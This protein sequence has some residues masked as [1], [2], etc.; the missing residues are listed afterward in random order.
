MLIPRRYSHF[1]YGAIQ[2]G[3]TTGVATAVATSGYEYEATSLLR[4]ATAWVTSWVLMMPLVLFVAPV[5]QRL[6]SLLTCDRP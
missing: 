2:S 5:I 3:L 6:T 4:W 1:V